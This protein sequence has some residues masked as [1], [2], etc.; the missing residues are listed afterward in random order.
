M[1]LTDEYTTPASEQ[2]LLTPEMLECIKD[3]TN[4]H[5]I[6]LRTAMHGLHRGGEHAQPEHLRLLL[7]CAEICQTSAHFMLRGSDLH[8]WTCTVCAEICA[9]CAEACDQFTDDTQMKAC[10]DACHGCA[11]SCRR[12]AEG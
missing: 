3:C 2:M 7:D 8:T 12:M 1:L 5:S 10:A 4:C 9:R 11:D 6:C